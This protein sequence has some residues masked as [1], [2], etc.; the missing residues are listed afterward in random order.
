VGVAV[1]PVQ[2]PGDLLVE[3]LEGSLSRL[4][5]VAHDGVHRL[6]LVVP[7]LAL[8]H[9]LGRDTTLGKIDVA[10][11]E[12]MSQPIGLFP[13]MMILLQAYPSP[14]RHGGR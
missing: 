4:G 11:V 12:P 10:C 13:R 9:I 5:D 1:F 3:V 7:L 8:D 2:G 6:A 14:Y